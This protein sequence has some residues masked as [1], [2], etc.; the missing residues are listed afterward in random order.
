MTGVQ[1][2]ITVQHFDRLAEAMN[3]LLRL[4]ADPAPMLDDLGMQ[5]LTLTQ[6]RF[7][8]ERDP[9]GGKWQPTQRGGAIL[10]DTNRLYQ[11]LTY[12]VH[13]DGVAVGS[14][15]V[16][17]AIHQFGGQAGRGR[18]VTIPARPY[19]GLGDGDVPI[20]E[21]VMIDHIERALAQAGAS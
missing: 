16:Y 14:N 6:D 4:R 10:R 15:V 1:A 11:S 5:W 13:A 9:D 12:E 3:G 17:S 20:L 2:R 19:L 8:A 18:K 7:E 21:G